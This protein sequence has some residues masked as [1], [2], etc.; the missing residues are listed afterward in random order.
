MIL[1]DTSV[2]IDFFRK[3]NDQLAALLEQGMV[4]CD[5]LVRTELACGNLTNRESTLAMLAL[6]PQTIR[7]RESEIL[8]LIESRRLY[9]MGLGAVDVSLLAA[10]MLTPA[11]R[12]W[13]LD[14]NL[15]DAARELAVSWN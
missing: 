10:T 13:T 4:L 1:A 8:D 6:L 11:A 2:W 14:R 9:G 5:V 7:P 12:L 15:G 3:G